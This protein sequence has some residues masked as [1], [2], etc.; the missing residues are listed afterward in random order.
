MIFFAISLAQS[1]FECFLA[2]L[3][4]SAS[5]VFLADHVVDCVYVV[6]SNSLSSVIFV[7][8]SLNQKIPRIDFI[9][10]RFFSQVHAAGLGGV[11]LRYVFSE[12]TCISLTVVIK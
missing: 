8:C 2:S 5:K 10:N 6:E 4:N 9:D 11:L 7:R 12:Y 3:A 1:F